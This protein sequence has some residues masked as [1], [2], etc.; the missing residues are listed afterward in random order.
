[1]SAT[2]PTRI[3]FCITDLDPGGAERALVQL[4]TRLD[5]SRWDPAVFC[6]SKRGALANDLARSGIPVTC[7]NAVRAWQAPRVVRQL[8]S[9]LKGWNPQILQT[10][11]FHANFLGRLAGWSAGVP[12]IVSGIRVAER[13]SRGHLA[14]DRWTERLVQTHVAVSQSVADFSV[15]HAGLSAQK[16]VVI[17]NGVDTNLYDHADPINASEVGLPDSSRVIITVG[18]LD[19]QK[20][21]FDLLNAAAGIVH[22]FRDVHFLIVGEGDL[23]GELESQIQAQGL[24]A[25][26]HLTGWRADVPRLL[27]RAELFVLPSLWEGLPNAV[28]EAMAAGLPVVC[29]R[30]E[31]AEELIEPERSG[32]LVSPGNSVDLQQAITR[33]LIDKNFG[34]SLGNAGKQRAREQFSWKQMAASYAALYERLLGRS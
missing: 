3:A 7:F 10:F 15:R 2:S 25:R 16:M 14:L 33:L 4:V 22:Q 8:R 6:L 34:K 26:V 30:V 13:R 1:M 28:L 5:H 29:T 17:H 21:L 19:R 24:E 11:L 9:A 18:R 23:R 32:L 20:G 12:H 31:G 27:N